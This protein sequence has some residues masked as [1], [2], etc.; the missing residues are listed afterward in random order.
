MSRPAKIFFVFLLFLISYF[1]FPIFS[2]SPIFAWFPDT[3]KFLCPSSLLDCSSAD[4][5]KFRENYQFGASLFHTCFDNKENCLARLVAKYNL[6]KYYDEGKTD[7]TLLAA[8]A[9]F[10][11][12]ANY[13]DHWGP[14]WLG[15]EEIILNKSK[16][17][18]LKRNTAGFIASEPTE[19]LAKIES[20]IKVVDFWTRIRLWK[21]VLIVLAIILIPVCFYCGFQ[22]ARGEQGLFV[23]LIPAFALGTTVLLLILVKIFY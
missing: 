7:Q 19:S 9:H 8:A 21:E 2:P 4:S 13:P 23:L 1:L 16:M 20:E 6:K 14:S 11:Q 10:Y 12:D 22:W 18:D 17:D 3:H 5:V 15:K